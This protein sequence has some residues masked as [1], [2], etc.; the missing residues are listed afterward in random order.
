MIS[1]TERRGM[2]RRLSTI[3]VLLIVA[4]LL[5]GAGPIYWL[6]KGAIS[7]TQESLRD[8]LA[9]W[10]AEARWSNLTEA[11]TTLEVGHYL[12]NTVVLVAGSWFTQLFVAATG[13]YALSI[14]RPS[15]GKY[16]YGAVLATLFLPATVSMVSLYLTVLDLGIANTPLSVWLPAG[17]HA[18]NVLLVKQFFD[19]IPRE[20]FEAARLDGAGAWRIF[21]SVVLPM[22]RPIL[23]VVSLLAVMNAWKDFLWPMIA[24]TDTESQPLAVAL[25]R[26]ADTSDQALLIAGM[27][28]AIIPPVAVFL[29]FQRQIIRGI[30][31]T[32]LKG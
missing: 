18:F 22:S 13:A 23:A 14:L 17:A 10:P 3:Q 2:R 30:A 1:D 24:I 28:I 12:T 11:W 15:Y 19:G 27:L 16:V 7:S 31:F 8:P 32:G 9:L 21:T 26:L 5:E 4:L 20:L 29:V 6:F 25:P